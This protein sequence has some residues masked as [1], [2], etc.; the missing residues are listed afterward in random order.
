MAVPGPVVHIKRTVLALAVV[1]SAGSAAPCAH[2]SG[3][4]GAAVD[5]PTAVARALANNPSLK[6]AAYAR[7]AAANEAL[8]ARGRL[9]PELIAEERFVRTNIPA[10]AF[11]LKMNQEGLQAADF[12]DVA[13]F[14]NPSPIDGFITTVGLT[15]PIFAPKAWVGYRMAGR[16]SEAGGFDLIRA[17]EETVY[18]V[19]T[20]YLD[21]LTAR[22]LLAAA[23]KGLDEAGEHH[24]I[25]E[26]SEKAGTGLASDV[27]RAKVSLAQAEAA[28]ASAE[29]RLALAR[30]GLALAMGEPGGA[31]VDAVSTLPPF[32]ADMTLEDRIARAAAQRADIRAL[33]LRAENAAGAVD[34]E[35]SG[36][37]PTVGLGGAYQLDSG[38]GILS[39]DNRTWKIGVSLSWTLFDGLRREAAVAKAK[40]GRA[41]ARELLRA[42]RD[43]AAFEVTQARL[44][45]DDAARRAAI[46]RQ[47]VAAAEEAARL[48]RARYENQL[49]R[50]VDLLDAQAALDRARADRVRAENDLL[51]ARADLERATGT[52]LSWAQGNAAAPTA[53][54]ER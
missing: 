13:R 35:R 50:M 45:A 14:N 34:L 9:L 30:S 2:A 27:L 18:R 10:E 41:G 23:K 1:I 24:R 31:S 19:V 26:V 52:L 42:A 4:A 5:F 38:G 17:G 22:E 12:A 47:A 49:A 44:A 28:V 39:P 53:G 43:A 6:A 48:I 15:Q 37:L 40:A 8:G 51:R 3:Q 36:Y 46:A 29:N 32:P 7:D 21:V 25:A 20:A 11:G 16:E 33:S 54:A